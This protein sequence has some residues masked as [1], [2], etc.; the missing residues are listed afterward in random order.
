LLLKT[1]AN[2]HIAS[3]N[4][5]ISVFYFACYYNLPQDTQA[6]TY[7]MPALR[8]TLKKENQ[9]LLPESPN[10]ALKHKELQQI[11]QKKEITTFCPRRE[12]HRL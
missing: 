10:A 8:S 9:D 6:H 1:T 11:E 2:K 7:S 4:I 12:D 5:Y 3:F